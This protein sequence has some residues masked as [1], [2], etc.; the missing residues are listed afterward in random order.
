MHH[1]LTVT[2][3]STSTSTCLVCLQAHALHHKKYEASFLQQLSVL[4]RRLGANAVRGQFCAYSMC[5]CLV[6]VSI[7]QDCKRWGRACVC[8]W[9][10][11]DVHH[12][13]AYC[14]YPLSNKHMRT[15]TRT[16]S[17]SVC[18]SH[19]HT[20]S[21]VRHPLILWLNYVATLAMALGIGA[22]YW[23]AGKDTGGIQVCVYACAYISGYDW[24]AGK[25]T[26]GIQV[27]LREGTEREGGKKLCVCVCWHACA[28]V[29]GALG[30]TLVCRGVCVCVCV[31]MCARVRVCS[32]GVGTT[33]YSFSR[34][35][36]GSLRVTLFHAVIPGDDG[37]VLTPPVEG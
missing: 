35:H 16:H 24:H 21:Q 37:P 33:S 13:N 34:S 20:C 30:R 4:A 7:W 15:H 10:V 27:R 12:A 28:C 6:H 5:T 36:T 18:L 31:C 11:V 22:I 2:Y 19:T 29:P 9:Q 32:G 14:T 23:H 8:L 3:A 17:L 25:D 26:G 1:T